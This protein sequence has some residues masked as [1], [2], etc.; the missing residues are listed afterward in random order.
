MRI[1]NSFEFIF[2]LLIVDPCSMEAR[3][4]DV[5]LAQGVH[6]HEGSHLSQKI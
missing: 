1:Y 6:A 3:V 2:Y 5:G 4:E